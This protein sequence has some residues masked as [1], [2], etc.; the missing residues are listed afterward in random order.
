MSSPRVRAHPF[1][2]EVRLEG[3]A[4][5]ERYIED[6]EVVE[7]LSLPTVKVVAAEMAPPPESE[8]VEN[9]PPVMASVPVSVVVTPVTE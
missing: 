6:W 4:P 9:A 1:K 7:V 2:N 8:P 5:R 3:E